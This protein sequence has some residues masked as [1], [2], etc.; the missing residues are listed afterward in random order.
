ML[1]TK[2]GV[3]CLT[4]LHLEVSDK[5]ILEEATIEYVE[6]EDSDEKEEKRKQRRIKCILE[7][8]CRSISGRVK[9]C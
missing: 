3:K 8:V 7:I 9:D 5:G 2:I 1:T 4:N 6:N